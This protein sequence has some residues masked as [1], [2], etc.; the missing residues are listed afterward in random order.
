MRNRPLGADV[1]IAIGIAVF[2]LVIWQPGL[3]WALLIAIAALIAV[4]VS[5]IRENRR[6]ARQPRGRRR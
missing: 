2:I 5:V 6:R 1:A 4:A 3:A